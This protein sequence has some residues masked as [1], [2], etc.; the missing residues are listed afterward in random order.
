MIV[1]CKRMHLLDRDPYNECIFRTKFLDPDRN[2]DH[3]ALCK[4]GKHGIILNVQFLFK[5]L[6]EACVKKDFLPAEHYE[7][8]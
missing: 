4:N 1:L 8:K 7:L 3:F 5:I 2:L 6:E